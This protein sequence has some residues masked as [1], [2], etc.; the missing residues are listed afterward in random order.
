MHRG[1]RKSERGIP[2]SFR[3]SEEKCQGPN[4]SRDILSG[5]QGIVG[6]LRHN[7]EPGRPEASG[8]LGAWLSEV[9]GGE[10]LLS[11][12]CP[13][14]S[15]RTPLASACSGGLREHYP[16]RKASGLNGQR[17]LSEG[18]A[19]LPTTA[20]LLAP[21]HCGR[22]KRTHAT[23]PPPSPLCLFFFII[24][25]ITF[26]TLRLLG[27]TL[28]GE[29]FGQSVWGPPLPPRTPGPR[30]PGFAAVSLTEYIKPIL[31]G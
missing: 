11:V 12:P 23:I 19:L 1:P 9:A 20:W 29:A 3:D 2:L 28:T 16:G 15:P 8:R 6:N 14:A 31:I 24:V 5:E 26:Q 30:G 18:A 22:T 7:K 25:I 4:V 27:L 13:A 21:G 10:L 17:L